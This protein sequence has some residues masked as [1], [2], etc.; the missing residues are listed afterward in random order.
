[1]RDYAYGFMRMETNS[2]SFRGPEI[3]VEKPP[4]TFRVLG[5]GDSAT[6]GTR[7]QEPETYLRVLEGELA[8]SSN[9]SA[10]V[11][12]EVINTGVGGYSTYQELVTL[13]RYGL[14]LCPDLVIV[15]FVHNDAY[16]STDLFNN[17]KTIHQPPGSELPNFMAPHE[18][19]YPSRLL[20][21]LRAVLKR[22]WK[23]F[24]SQPAKEAATEGAN[25]GSWTP[26]SFALR[27]WPVHQGHLQRLKSLGETNGFH[28]LVVLLPTYPQVYYGRGPHAY[29]NVVGPFLAAEKIPYIDL[30]D[31]FRAARTKQQFV[32][33]VHPSVAGH[34]TTASEILRYLRESHWLDGVSPATLRKCASPE[35][36]S[37]AP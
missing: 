3:S 4:G 8:K 34:Q 20:T 28:V 6:W 16:P 19:E 23:S 35:R 36:R 13:E 26:D 2:L 17:L 31:V 12:F 33:W 1:V 11:H 18:I 32:D 27:W 7:V 22:Q 9:Q 30:Y 15:G 10:R 5:L 29:Q 24:R 21:F 37:P 25:S 14:P